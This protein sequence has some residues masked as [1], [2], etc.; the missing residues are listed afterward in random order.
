MSDEQLRITAYHEAGHAICA[1]AGGLKVQRVSIVEDQKSLG[2]TLLQMTD[3]EK[4][5]LKSGDASIIRLLT[6]YQLGGMA[7]DYAR[8]KKSGGTEHEVA[9]GTNEDQ[10]KAQ[11]YLRRID[12]QKVIE[13][14]IGLAVRAV[15]AP[16]NERTLEELTSNLLS[17]RELSDDQLS[18][19]AE[20]VP[21]H[22]T[23]TWDVIK[24]ALAAAL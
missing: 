19:W 24:Y 8:W 9:R 11:E 2:H 15:G 14:Y 1:W 22:T 20:A 18:Q 12:E 10:V 13:T 7:G 6:L 16:E 4:A 17:K 21:R 23:A 5:A 3:E